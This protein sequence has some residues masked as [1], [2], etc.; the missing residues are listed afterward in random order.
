MHAPP[1]LR[2]TRKLCT[3]SPPRAPRALFQR[4]QLFRGVCPPRAPRASAPRAAPPPPSVNFFVSFRR[5]RKFAQVSRADE[6]R[7]PLAVGSAEI[8][9]T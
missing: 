2:V 3:P 6:K 7:R 8:G 5:G 1:P 4:P 9:V